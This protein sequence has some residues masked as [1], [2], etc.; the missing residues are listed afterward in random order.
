MILEAGAVGSASVIAA[1][2]TA[3]TDS[4]AAA[5]PDTAE[6]EGRP[7]DPAA[8]EP[9]EVP[10]FR[11]LDSRTFLNPDGT[12]TSEYL[13]SPIHFEDASGQLKVIDTEAIES[14]AEGAAFE[15]KRAPVTTRLADSSG[16]QIVTVLSRGR[17]VTFQP[18]QPLDRRGTAPPASRS[19]Q[20]GQPAGQVTYTDV[21]PGVDLRYTLL[22]TGVKEDIVLTQPGD[23]YRFAFELSAPGLTPRL[24]KDGSVEIGTAREVHFRLPAPFMVDSSDADFGGGERSTDV[25]YELLTEQGRTGLV[26]AADPA[27]LADPDRVY[28]VYVDPTTTDPAYTANRDTF[29]SS[30]YPSLALDEQWN[31]AEGGYY[32][33]WNGRYDS[34]SGNNYAFVRTGIRSDVTVTDA[35]F[36]IYVQHAY[37]GSNATGIQIGRLTS[38]FTESQTWN[39]THPTYTFVDSDQV[40]HKCPT[41]PT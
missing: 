38:S 20:K 5:P 10:A 39:M 12:Y 35:E 34:G 36:K 29:I 16:S 15:T 3:P 28:P 1:P 41:P 26:I 40:A 22:P 18:T 17:S 7:D 30:A 21:Y 31:A 19:P 25:H 8:P 11:T 27:W 33:L 9:V 4:T 32:E 13:P 23:L 6:Q 14:A 2:T 37:S 24:L